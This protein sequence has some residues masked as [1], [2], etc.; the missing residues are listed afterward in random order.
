MTLQEEKERR[1]KVRRSSR[2]TIGIPVE[3][4]GIDGSGT[5]V[6]EKTTTK[7]LS[8]FGACILLRHRF[9]GGSEIGISIPHLGRQQKCRVVWV[10][11]EPGE[12]GAYE[13]GIELQTAEDFWGVQ[14]PPDD[15]LVPQ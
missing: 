15:W 4:S 5:E 14:F 2:I 1:R 3:V 9:S 11:M 7:L 12:N 10:A 8:R 13:T 6:Q